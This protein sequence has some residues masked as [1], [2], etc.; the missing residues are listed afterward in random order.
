MPE[1]K[2]GALTS[3]ATPQALTFPEEISE[4]VLDVVRA[5]GKPFRLSGLA[6]LT[7]QSAR[8]ADR[9]GQGFG[10]VEA[11]GELSARHGSIDPG[12]LRALQTEMKF[13]LPPGAAE[14]LSI[15]PN[16]VEFAAL[17]RFEIQAD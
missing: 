7:I 8:W 4:R 6:R 13:R 5:A 12:L 11:R 2:S 10:W 14:E 15:R 9:P 1:S 17:E 16:D 3:L